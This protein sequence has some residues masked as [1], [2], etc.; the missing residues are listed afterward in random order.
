MDSDYLREHLKNKLQWSK[1]YK[2]PVW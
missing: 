2:L 1:K